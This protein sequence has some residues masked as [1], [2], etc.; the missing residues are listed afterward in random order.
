M[1]FVCANC[2]YKDEYNNLPPAKDIEKRH[3]PG[4]AYSDVECPQCGALCFPDETLPGRS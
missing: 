2:G 3:D 4:D 1:I